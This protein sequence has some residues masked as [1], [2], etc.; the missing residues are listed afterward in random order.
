[1]AKCYNRYLTARGLRLKIE[2]SPSE[3]AKI[4]E[5][6][7][8]LA[9][10]FDS[11]GSEWEGCN[12]LASDSDASNPSGIDSDDSATTSSNNDKHGSGRPRRGVQG[13]RNNSLHRSAGL[14]RQARDIHVAARR[15]RRDASSK[16][17]GVGSPQLKT[18]VRDR[19]LSRCNQALLT[20]L[21]NRGANQD[22]PIIVS[23]GST[24]ATDS[25]SE[26]MDGP[27]RSSCG[28]EGR[29]HRSTRPTSVEDREMTTGPRVSQMES[30]QNP[31]MSHSIQQRCISRTMFLPSVVRELNALIFLELPS[32]LRRCRKASVQPGQTGL[33]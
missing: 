30:I 6:E 28:E 32:C 20:M 29:Q 17:V 2:G 26:Q 15:T 5:T 13:R 21:K 23:E 7:R 14:R 19:I 9:K 24:F 33:T 16:S 12:D 10:G 22:D 1:M 31:G 27:D 18:D 4:D 11:S 25:D 8:R 3:K